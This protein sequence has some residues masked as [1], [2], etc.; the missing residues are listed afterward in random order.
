[1]SDDLKPLEIRQIQTLPIQGHRLWKLDG[2]DGPDP[3][4]SRCARMVLSAEHQREGAVLMQITTIGLDIA[5][6]VF[7]VHGIDGEGQ[8]MLRRKVR[9]DQSLALFVGLEPCLIGMES[10]ATAHHWA[11]ELVALG[12]EVKLMPPAYCK[13]PM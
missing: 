1:M 5:K 12:H 3:T 4:A 2:V 11:R 8:V 6:N 7:Q 13:R 9:R 10:C